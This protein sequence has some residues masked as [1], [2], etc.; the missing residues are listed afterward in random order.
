MTQRSD[1]YPIEE[2]LAGSVEGELEGG[3]IHCI[4]VS[5]ILRCLV[6]RIEPVQ[7]LIAYVDT[8]I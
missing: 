1:S 4:Q 3:G 8:A 2:G 6:V 5:G 7:H